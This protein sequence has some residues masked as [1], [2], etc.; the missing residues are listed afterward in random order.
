MQ[1][2]SRV[3]RRE[4]F[5]TWREKMSLHLCDAHL[6]CKMDPEKKRTFYPWAIEKSF[7]KESG[8]KSATKR[9]NNEPELF[10]EISNEKESK[11]L[12]I[13]TSLCS[14]QFQE[15]FLVEIFACDK[16]NQSQ[17]LINIYN[18]PDIENYSGELKKV[19]N[20]QYVKKS[21]LDKDQKLLLLHSYW[22]SKKK[23]LDS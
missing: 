10:I 13:I 2:D 4:L 7:T 18:I 8:S 11:I 6:R 9:S 14:P 1:A 3:G 22:L 23:H 17:G 5:K 12:P 19:H 21:N 20:L 16:I 15:R